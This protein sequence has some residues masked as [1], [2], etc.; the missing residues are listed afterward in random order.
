[1]RRNYLIPIL[2]ILL[3]IG[4]ISALLS[5][6]KEEK[7]FSCY[8]YDD[9]GRVIN[10]YWS[11]TEEMWY[12]FLLS[13]QDISDVELHCTQEIVR[14]STGTVSQDTVTEGFRTSGD[15]L[16]LTLGDG[17]TQT[18]TALQST[19][20]CVYIDLARGEL[21]DIHS[22]KN[23][24]FDNNSVY[25]MDPSESGDLS[26]ENSVRIKGRGNSSWN[27]YEK[28]GYQLRFNR[29][30]S[31]LG[32][33]PAEKWVLLA[34]A[35][36]DSMMRT[37]L[38]SRMAK[39]FDL[40]FAA[41]FAYVDLWIDGE[42]LG[43]YLLGEKVDP[44]ASRLNLSEKTG[45]IFEHDETFY[46]EEEHW[47][48]SQKLNRHFVLKEI[49][50]EGEPLA[51]SAMADFESA[52]DELIRYLYETPSERVTLAELSRMID[53]D[54]FIQYFLINEYALNRESFATSFYWYKDG[55]ED[56]L[57]LGPI[58]DFDTC[59]GNDG[60][61]YTAS[62]GENHVMFRYLLA[63]P[64]FYERTMVMLEEYGE[65]LGAL[66]DDVD[67]LRAEIAQSAKMNYLRWDVLGKPNPKGGA[68]FAP[69]FDKAA[70]TLKQ[71]LAGREDSFRVVRSKVATSVVSEDCR[72]I[73]VFFQP[74]KDYENV[75]VAL[76]SLENGDDD[77]NWYRAEKAEDGRWKCRINLESYNCAGLYYYSVYTD[78]QQTVLAT[79]RNYVEKACAALYN[80]KAEITEASGELVLE[81]EDTTGTATGIRFDIWGAS[82]QETSFHRLQAKQNESGIWVAKLPVC[83]FNLPAEE[84]LII[85]PYV[86]EQ[87]AEQKL[88]EKVFPVEGVFSHTC[89]TGEG[90]VCTQCGRVPGVEEFLAKTPIYRLCNSATGERFYTGS[91]I[92]KK[93]LLGGGWIDEG[94]AWYAP[95]FGGDPVYRL[96]KPDT[97]ERCFTLDTE[98]VAMMESSGWLCEGICWGSPA[99]GDPVYRMY[100]PALTTGGVIY[101]A[102]E[103]EKLALIGRGWVCEDVCWHCVPAA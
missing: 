25:I 69:T 56:V 80:L 39:N 50:E 83:A 79:G 65:T 23:R 18:V 24:K 45:A 16:V 17:T 93:T 70:D 102:S 85:R 31:V 10:G 4:V 97:N 3:V 29:E 87:S 86:E 21:T 9:R 67:T 40:A 48:L 63:V 77:I 101:T 46:L 13:T 8:T 1:M 51:L 43:T 28:K 54:S 11:E 59:M 35:G 2:T 78:H 61:P 75:V 7:G 33:N 82:V 98:A 32:M 49:V 66:A 84:T 62:Y 103:E 26:E 22:D 89:P 30:V 19:L 68:D 94:I 55:P 74:E 44:T 91:D 71:W 41:S 36:D 64:A 60:E 5:I 37:Q 81:L 12:L 27:E 38:I 95:V 57:H 53:V 76:W 47:F 34:N 20:P 58:W 73:T 88:D 15:Q 14:A 42:Y 52:V 92:E 99:E 90:G 96:V 72:T 6:Q 100:D